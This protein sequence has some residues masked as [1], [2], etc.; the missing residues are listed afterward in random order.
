ML[1]HGFNMSADGLCLFLAAWVMCVDLGCGFA[2]DRD[3]MD[4]N[5]RFTI[6]IPDFYVLFEQKYKQKVG[7]CVFVHFAVGQE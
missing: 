1:S 7:V 2:D 5:A 3:A 4:A 6:Y